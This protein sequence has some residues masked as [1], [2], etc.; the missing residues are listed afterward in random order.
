MNGFDGMEEVNN[1]LDSEHLVKMLIMSLVRITP[2][3]ERLTLCPVR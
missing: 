2:L 1:K 3:R